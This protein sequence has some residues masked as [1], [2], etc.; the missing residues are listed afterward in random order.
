MQRLAK[1]SVRG[2]LST[3]CLSHNSY[4]LTVTVAQFVLVA[5]KL[6]WTVGLPLLNGGGGPALGPFSWR[7]LPL[8][9]NCT[10]A[11]GCWR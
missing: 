2:A 11:A 8:L 4:L 5:L 6:A 7:L 1:L 10:T 3:P 9:K